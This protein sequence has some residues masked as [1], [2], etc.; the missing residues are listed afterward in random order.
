MYFREKGRYRTPVGDFAHPLCDLIRP[1]ELRRKL[2]RFDS[3]SDP[4]GRIHTKIRDHPLQTP[5]PSDGCLHNSFV[6]FAPLSFWPAPL[7]PS[8]SSVAPVPVRQ[9]NAPR[10]GTS[11]AEFCTSSHLKPHKVPFQYWHESCCCR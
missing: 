8:L 4:G 5:T 6:C 9:A 7:S 1:D 2:L 10:L 11:I 3:S